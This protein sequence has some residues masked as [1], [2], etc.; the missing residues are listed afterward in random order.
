MKQN[1]TK[2]EETS[3]DKEKNINR[4]KLDKK[5]LSEV[6]YQIN[7]TRKNFLVYP[8]GHVQTNQSIKKCHALLHDL[9]ELA[10]KITIGVA[11]DKLFVGN[12]IIE[13]KGHNIKDLALSI[14]NHE[15]AGVT[16]KKKISDLFRTFRDYL[17]SIF[18]IQTVLESKKYSWIL[19]NR[20]YP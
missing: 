10:P 18:R 2:S 15:L 7:I 6:L 16:Y 5:L 11:K 19:K 8:P 17:L 4:P 20:V 14:Q 3:K 12:T 13:D 1:E 9:L